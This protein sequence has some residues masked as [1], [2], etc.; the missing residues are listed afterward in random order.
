MRPVLNRWVGGYL[1]HFPVTE[2]K[3]TLLR[4]TRRLIT[5]AEAQQT[6]RTRHGFS[7]AR[8]GAPDFLKIDVEDA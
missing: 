2:G 6:A 4:L 8:F 3:K 5:P 7:L 1:A